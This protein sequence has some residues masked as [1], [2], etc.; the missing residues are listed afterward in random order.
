MM[1]IIINYETKGK[2]KKKKKMKKEERK[3]ERNLEEEKDYLW[4]WDSWGC[5]IEEKESIPMDGVLTTQSWFFF[6]FFFFFLVVTGAKME[7]KIDWI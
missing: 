1:M 5:C 3:K 7:T 6:F 2:R 4:G